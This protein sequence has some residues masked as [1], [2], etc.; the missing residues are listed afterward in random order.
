ML[1]YIVRHGETRANVEG[2][3]QGQSDD[4]MTDGGRELAAVTG[5]AMK[6]IKFDRCISSP[7]SRARETAEIILRETGNDIPVTIDDRLKEVNMGS[8][9][10][11]KFR[12]GECE[13]DREQLRIFFTDPFR[14]EGFPGGENIQQLCERTQDFL[15]EL[16]AIDD[17]RTYLIAT[18]GVALRAMLNFLYDDPSDFWH[19]HVPYNLAVNIIE[20]NSGE[21]RLIADDKLYYDSE[22]AVDQ[23]A[24][25]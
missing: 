12:P 13:V 24:R 10:R 11:K 16:I 2:Y 25:Y 4:G 19:G 9:E 5:R 22:D 6:G 15:K 21:G 18:H 8:L 14:F 23:Y 7:L 20:G 3:L 17:D 1:I